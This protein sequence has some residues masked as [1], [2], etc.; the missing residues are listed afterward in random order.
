[1]RSNPIG[2][3]CN[4]NRTNEHR[5]AIV[6]LESLSVLETM[7]DLYLKQ[8]NPY[9]SWAVLSDKFL[10]LLNDLYNT[11]NIGCV[12]DLID[13]YNGIAQ[14]SNNNQALFQIPYNF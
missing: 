4:R 13:T 9:I 11:Q 12:S 8:N 1:M 6:A 2:G 10:R 14:N 3:M 7:K 5:Y